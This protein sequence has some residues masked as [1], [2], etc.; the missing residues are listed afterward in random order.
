MR[1]YISLFLFLSCFL[2]IGQNKSFKISGTVIAGDTKAPL[3]SATVYLERIKDSSLI[4]YTISDKNGK[5]LLEDST[6]DP[7]LNL[8][9]SYVGYKTLFKQITI[10]KENIVL[11]DLLLD[12]DDNA[13]DEVLIKT[14]APVT[15]KKD[16]LE[17]NV[18]SFKT[19]KDATVEDLLK[20]LPGVEVD[21][22]GKITV[23]GKEVSN[24]LVNGKPFFSDDPTIATRN[25]TKEIIEKVQVVDTKSKSEAFTGEQGDSENKTINLTISEENNKGVFGRVAAGGGTDE[26][27]EYAG[28]VNV[29]ND[30]QRISVLAGGNNTNTPGFSF[31]EI[32][33]MFGRSSTTSISSNGAFSIDGRSFGGGEGIVTSRNIG[34]NYA[35]EL[36]KGFDIAA[37]YFYSESDSEN[38]VITKREN[39]LPDTRFFTNSQRSTQ[40][41]N[42]NHS[43][44]TS[45]DI[46]VDSTFLINVRP[47]FRY[48]TTTRVNESSEESFD[49]DEVLTNSS[50][51]SSFRE[52]EIRNFRN[53]LDITKRLGVKGSFIK[54]LLDLTFNDTQGEDF[55][56]SEALFENPNQEDV[57]RD[58]F[59]DEKAASNRFLASATYR[60]PIKAK[61]LFL[62]FGLQFDRN[63]RTTINSTFDFNSTNQQYT[64]FNED[65]STDFKYIDNSTRPSLKFTIN[66]EK[67]SFS[68]N[69]SYVLRTLDNRDDL[70]P[71]LSL[72]ENFKAIEAGAFFNVKI[73]E[74]ANFYGSYDL[75]NSPPQ[76]NELTPFQN[77]TDPLNTI[78]GN[79]NL[80]P[81]NTHNMYMSYNSYDF[82]KRTGFFSYFNV[83]AVNNQVVTK[84]VVDENFVRNTTFENVDGNY[85]AYGFVNYSKS[86]KIDSLRT[87]KISTGLSANTNRAIN[88]N[89][90]VQYASLNQSVT[91]SL[92]L[93]L[94][95]RD[96][97][98]LKPNYRIAFTR[99]TF[100]LPDFDNR[101]FTQHNLSINTA[102]F[103]PKRFEWRNNVNFT[104]NPDV[105][106]GFQKAI[107]FWN[108]TL[109]YSMFEDKATLTLKVYDLLNQNN[110]SRRI[111]RSNFIQDSESTVLQRFVMLS[112]SYKF[113]SLGS[114]GETTDNGFFI[115]D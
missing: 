83:T 109:A 15:I 17:F 33:K 40:T 23:N 18:K 91:P 25:L 98:E 11:V 41:D 19:K 10:D 21:E 115:I 69:T 64:D 24:I 73:N 20:Q 113:N 66:K 53:D 34:T 114:K 106:P 102:T 14:S 87:L 61:E 31:G 57:I 12:I 103:L 90:G 60:M 4:T 111:S 89:N 77:V 107:W 62:D 80:E 86:V 13:L 59:T 71:E 78:T 28:I 43:F 94:N 16:T 2:S 74:K 85:T 101:A 88:F 5:F 37:D 79:P 93:T 108:T 46:E 70:R 29:F 92:G 65:L 99:N 48:G 51:A 26:R 55:L 110:N 95:W 63:T 8:Y 44:N 9:I 45:I 27:Y 42:T 58:Q 75:T 100:D 67:W 54:A 84:S 76:I 104:Y 32:Q 52:S 72:K 56:K 112:F 30:D 50:T 105:S 7:A 22:D 49:Q 81:T 3:E 1:F 96:V 82:Q 36:G 47:T 38:E 68:A 6:Y 35:D 97:M 39:I